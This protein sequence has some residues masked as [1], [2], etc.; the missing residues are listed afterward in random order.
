MNI[1]LWYTQE[2]Y[3]Q[4]NYVDTTGVSIPVTQFSMKF[5]AK[6]KI[7]PCEQENPHYYR[8]Q[9]EYIN[10]PCG[11]SLIAKCLTSEAVTETFICQVE[12]Y[13]LAGW[14]CFIGK[15]DNNIKIQN[16]YV[17]SVCG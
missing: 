4:N 1:G 9:T 3:Y 10:L 2:E 17:Q 12:S 5:E 6:A 15:R 16:V 8:L 14:L 7:T 11:D 13:L